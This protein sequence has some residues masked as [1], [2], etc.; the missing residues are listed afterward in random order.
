MYHNIPISMS[1]DKSREVC[2]IF[3]NFVEPMFNC[4]V[5]VVL[6]V[7][8]D[9]KPI[10]EFGIISTREKSDMEHIHFK[11]C[12]WKHGLQKCDASKICHYKN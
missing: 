2:L 10:M 11:K 6:L 5:I 9:F 3:L 4:L 12:I 7:Y 1:F 8:F